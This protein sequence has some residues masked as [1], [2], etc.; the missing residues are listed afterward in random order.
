MNSNQIEPLNRNRPAAAGAPWRAVRMLPR[1]LFA[2]IMAMLVLFWASVVVIVAVTFSLTAWD[3]RGGQNP[4][5]ALAPTAT[6]TAAPTVEEKPSRVPDSAQLVQGS[7]VLGDVSDRIYFF[8]D[9]SCT[10]GILTIALTRAAVYSETPC[11]QALPA[12]SVR[13]LI[14]QPVR[15]RIIGARMLLEALF[16]GVF[17]FD[18][19]RAWVQIG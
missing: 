15:V 18:V 1:R 19:G 6:V 3:D 13:R 5:V 10:D 12:D 14:G 9:S 7:L 2:V 16:V 11:A 17:E 4:S 8:A